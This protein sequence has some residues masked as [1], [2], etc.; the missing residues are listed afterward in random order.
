MTRGITNELSFE[1]QIFQDN[2]QPKKM[3]NV[4]YQ[5]KLDILLK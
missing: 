5:K 1:H 3:E 4:I 2:L